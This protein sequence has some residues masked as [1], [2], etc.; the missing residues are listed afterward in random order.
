MDHHTAFPETLLK[1]LGAFLKLICLP[2]LK[3]LM[4]SGI[5]INNALAD[6]SF[7]LGAHTAITRLVG[8]GVSLN[9]LLYLDMLISNVLALGQQP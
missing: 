2:H 7:L 4:D 9:W 1:F 8:G 6:L 5:C 3:L